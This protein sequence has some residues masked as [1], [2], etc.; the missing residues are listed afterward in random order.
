VRVVDPL[1]GPRLFPLVVMFGLT[2]LGGLV[3]WSALSGRAAIAEE[4]RASDA[5]RSIGWILGGLLA[6]AALVETAGFVVGA[7]V[8]FAAVARGFGAMRLGRNLAVGLVI[9]G[10][11]FVCF[12]YGLGL[13][14]PGPAF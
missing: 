6:F 10:I 14:L 8:L 1:L 13:N 4:P 7:G 9:A 5:L 11:V 12:V 3:A 2:A